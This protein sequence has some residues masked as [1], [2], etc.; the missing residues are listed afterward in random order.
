MTFFLN[1]LRHWGCREKIAPLD[2]G[3]NSAIRGSRC[4]ACA[5]GGDCRGKKPGLRAILIYGM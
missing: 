4:L 2:I 5:A 1:F 3:A